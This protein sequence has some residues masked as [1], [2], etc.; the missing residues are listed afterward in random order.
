[1]ISKL[2]LL[3]KSVLRPAALILKAKPP[4][5]VPVRSSGDYI[6]PTQ[7]DVPLPRRLFLTYVL[8]VYWE[9]I[10]LF[11][12][13]CTSLTIMVISIVWAINNKVDVVYTTHNREC[14][15]RTMDLRN[16]SIH[17]ML[18]INQRY[19]PWPEMQDVLDKMTSAQKRAIKRAESCSHP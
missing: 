1:M 12:V 17:K 3:T 16:P 19:E 15:S 2:A 4:S 18:L 10:P 6:P 7:Y 9:I 8:N 5:R 14:I 11:L 13:T